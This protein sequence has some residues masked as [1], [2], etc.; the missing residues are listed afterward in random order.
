MTDIQ[1]RIIKIIVDD[2]SVN[3]DTEAFT[4][5]RVLDM[6]FEELKLDSLDFV[7]IVYTIED[8]LNISVPDDVL[9]QVKTFRDIFEG[10]EK[11]FMEKDMKTASVA[12]GSMPSAS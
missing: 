4:S 9:H 12:T 7:T 11:L 3:L 6:T 10:I 8:E 1:E 2:P 5:G